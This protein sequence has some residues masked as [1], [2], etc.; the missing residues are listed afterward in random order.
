M[1]STEILAAPK[2]FSPS[3]KLFRDM[4]QQTVAHSIYSLVDC[5]EIEAGTFVIV[6]RKPGGQRDV[7]LIGDLDA[8]APSLNRAKIRHL[9][10]G[11]GASLATTEVHV[12]RPMASA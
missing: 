2:A 1:F 4:A 10:A 11:L 8:G 7:L 6:D 12:Y 9:G 3:L 5:P